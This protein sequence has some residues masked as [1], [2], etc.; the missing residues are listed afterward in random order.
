[1]QSE[2]KRPVQLLYPLEIHCE[3]DETCETEALV[4]ETPND[5]SLPSQMTLDRLL[6]PRPDAAQRT[7][8]L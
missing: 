5:S 1:M 8:E 4:N 6:C 2:L 7:E 3:L